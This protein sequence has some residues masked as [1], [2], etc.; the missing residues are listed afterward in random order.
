MLGLACVG[1]IWLTCLLT[2]WVGQGDEEDTAVSR[3]Q[4]ILCLNLLGTGD[5]RTKKTLVPAGP[6]PGR[7]TNSNLAACRRCAVPGELT[8]ADALPLLYRAQYHCND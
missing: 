4:H 3:F 8:G 5:E 2:C 7:K 6:P 1:V